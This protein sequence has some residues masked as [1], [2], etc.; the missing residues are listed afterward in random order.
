M[1]WKGPQTIK[2]APLPL[3]STSGV[4]PPPPDKI[5]KSI[6]IKMNLIV[7]NKFGNSNNNK[8]GISNKFDW[9]KQQNFCR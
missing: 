9:F 1:P 4:E 5:W 6:I 3:C 7:H 8:A 2:V